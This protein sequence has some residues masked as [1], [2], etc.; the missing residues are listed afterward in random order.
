MALSADEGFAPGM[1]VTAFALAGPIELGLAFSGETQILGYSRGQ[2]AALAG[3]RP[4]WDRLELDLAG[5][6]GTAGIDQAGAFLSSDP[7]ASGS[8]EFVGGR[9][10]AMMALFVSRRGQVR[11]GVGASVGYEHDLDQY[12]VN[13]RYVEDDSWFGDEPYETTRSKQIGGAERWLLRVA[14]V[15]GLQ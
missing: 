13:Y 4:R 7:G 6:V 5:V 1:S 14:F 2:I 8:V 9:I 15:L 12:D 3:V 11:F 10:G